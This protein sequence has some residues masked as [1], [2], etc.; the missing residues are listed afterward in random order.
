MLWKDN[1]KVL[2]GG[3]DAAGVD[4]IEERRAVHLMKETNRRKNDGPF[5][6]G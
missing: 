1:T 5:S 6:R 4:Q 2:T 3:M